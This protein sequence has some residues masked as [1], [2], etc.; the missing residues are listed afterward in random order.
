MSNHGSIAGRV[1]DAAGGPLA[2]A[3]VAIVE[4]E[5]PYREIGAITDAGG[6]FRFGLILPGAYRLAAHFQSRSGSGQVVVAADEQT[7][8]EIRIP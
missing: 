4:G 6:A 8:L 2:G 7:S 1:T 3:R 5:Q